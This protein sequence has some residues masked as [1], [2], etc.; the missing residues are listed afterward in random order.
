MAIE[1]GDAAVVEAQTASALLFAENSSAVASITAEAIL[2]PAVT[3]F[4]WGEQEGG[5]AKNV[6]RPRPR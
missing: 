2:P 5:E 4:P 3:L 1:L 6:G